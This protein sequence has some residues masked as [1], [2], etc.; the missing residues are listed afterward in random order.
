[1]SPTSTSARSRPGTTRRSRSSNPGATLPST[2][3]T[4]VFRSDSSGDTFAFTDYLASVSPAWKS[5]VGTGT[6]VSFPTGIGGKGNSGVGGVLSRQDGTIAYIAISY[7]FANKFDYALL[8]NAAGAYPDP[9]DAS[10]ISAAA[11]TASF[12]AG[13][14]ASI[15]NPPASAANAYPLSTFTYALVHRSSPKAAALKA[16]LTYAIGDGQQ[17]GKELSFAPLS[18]AVLATDRKAIASIR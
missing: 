17:F 1:M 16:F 5:K 12:G 9:K 13:T 4:P 11:A 10:T 2:G 14:T 6:Q 18:P 15:V 8:R 3:I 7:V